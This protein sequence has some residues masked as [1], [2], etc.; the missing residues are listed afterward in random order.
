MEACSSRTPFVRVLRSASGFRGRTMTGG[1]PLGGARNVVR[2][3]G[4]IPRPEVNVKR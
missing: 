4:G 1:I 2:G 3:S